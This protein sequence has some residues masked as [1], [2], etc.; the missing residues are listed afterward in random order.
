MRVLIIGGSSKI[1][2]HIGEFLSRQHEILYAGRREAEFFLDL[3]R[4]DDHFPADQKFEAVIHCAADFGG[5]GE[6]DFLRS[7]RVNSVG[8]LIVARLARQ[9]EAS[10]LLVLSSSSAYYSHDHPFYNAYA[11][12]KRH[13]D[14]LVS[15]YSERFSLPLTIFRPTQI[16]GDTDGYRGHQP[17][18]Y[19]I[20]DQAEQGKD[21]VLYGQND[22]LRNYL[23][24]DDLA[25]VVRR[26][27]ATRTTGVFPVTA[28]RSWVLSEIAKI[29]FGVFGTR[30]RVIFD[31]ARGDIPDLPLPD[32]T[33]FFNEIGM[34]RTIDLPE[35][36][37][38][39]AVTRRAS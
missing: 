22:A 23:H 35:G 24:V 29:A 10:H 34:T 6:N 33:S 1:G 2:R 9:V 31:P 5:E 30:G 7:E 3:E 21:V 16:Y 12:T 26:V 15:L 39:I 17:L 36:I 28:L 37:R 14:E 8:S 11:I 25:E 4:L 20:I 27:L 32:S 38:R 19:H 18:L 13:G